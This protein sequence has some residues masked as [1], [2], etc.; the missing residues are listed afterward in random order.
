MHDVMG[1]LFI[2]EKGRAQTRQQGIMP[3]CDG[4]WLSRATVINQAL[5]VRAFCQAALQFQP[6]YIYGKFFAPD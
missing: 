2:C 3:A 1:V 4:M 5:W 6:D